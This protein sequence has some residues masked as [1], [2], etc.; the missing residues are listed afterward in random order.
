M[1]PRPP[2]KIYSLVPPPQCIH[3]WD[4]Y[5]KFFCQK[6]KITGKTAILDPYFGCFDHITWKMASQGTNF[7]SGKVFASPGHPEKFLARYHPNLSIFGTVS[8]VCSV[9]NPKLL[10]D[11]PCFPVTALL[12]EGISFEQCGDEVK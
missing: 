1:H 9:K 3:F 12:K 5:Q 7:R 6:P 2:Q 8:R 4:C 10:V 11:F